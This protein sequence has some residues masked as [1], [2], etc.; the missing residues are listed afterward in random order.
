[1]T[2]PAVGRVRLWLKLLSDLAWGQGEMVVAGGAS[3][4]VLTG[5]RIRSDQHGE[6]A[7]P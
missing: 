5:P 6:R 7:G 2:S 3:P 4:T 1:M